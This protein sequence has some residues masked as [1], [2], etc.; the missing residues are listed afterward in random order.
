MMGSFLFPEVSSLSLLP[1]KRDSVKSFGMRRW[2]AV[3]TQ[4]RMDQ[5]LP[6]SARSFEGLDESQKFR[7]DK[8]VYQNVGT[9]CAI[10]EIGLKSEW[11]RA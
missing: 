7:F 5:T 3:E 4:K 6:C 1:D 9:V 8:D 11:G 10:H 2:C